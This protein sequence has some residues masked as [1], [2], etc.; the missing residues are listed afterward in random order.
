M[1]P[2]DVK[3]PQK[4]VEDVVHRMMV[5]YEAQGVGAEIVCSK[6]GV[7]VNDC[8]NVGKFFKAYV[9]ENNKNRNLLAI[10]PNMNDKTDPKAMQSA[11]LMAYN[12][13]ER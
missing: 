8:L 12:D 6:F 13:K 9:D 7:E 1:V 4:L 10:A 2:I 11:K 3:A 5:E